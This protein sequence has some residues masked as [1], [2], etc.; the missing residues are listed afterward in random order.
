MKV[1]KYFGSQRSCWVMIV[2]VVVAAM[3]PSPTWADP[4]QGARGMV[5]SVHPLATDAGLNA[6][7]AGGN[8]VDAAVATALTLGVV[9]GFNSGIGGGCFILIR[10]QDGTLLAI[11]G[12]EMAPAK[13]HRD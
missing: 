4:G 10:R 7:K 12:R 11:D 13:A 5:V 6:L 2:L 3:G 1:C 8:A 9:D